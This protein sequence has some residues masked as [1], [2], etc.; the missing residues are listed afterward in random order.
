MFALDS[1]FSLQ[2]LAPH[3]HV[4]NK[5]HTLI[6]L[7]Y[8]LSMVHNYY[9]DAMSITSIDFFTSQILSLM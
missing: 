8:K 9:S 4:S 7:S 3:V 6:E 5:L 2:F 1:C